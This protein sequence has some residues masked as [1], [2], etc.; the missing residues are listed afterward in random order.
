MTQQWFII[1]IP[2]LSSNAFQFIFIYIYICI[3]SNYIWFVYTL[4]SFN[5]CFHYPFN[6]LY[7]LDV[8]P[9]HYSFLVFY[10]C[11]NSLLIFSCVCEH[12]DYFQTL[13]IRNQSVM[14]ICVQVFVWK[15]AFNFLMERARSGMV[16][17]Y[18][19]CMTYFLRT[20]KLF[21]KWFYPLYPCNQ[22]TKCSSS[23]FLQ[24]LDMVNLF[25][26]GYFIGCVIV[27][28]LALSIYP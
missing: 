16:A 5:L 15:Y 18:C 13:G 28:H 24:M 23:T 7:I 14:N 21:S 20:M 19:Q 9:V 2:L 11:H 17:S 8:S 6:I 10:Y 12:L 3:L 25:N 4:T 22:C 26:I 27:S 1:L